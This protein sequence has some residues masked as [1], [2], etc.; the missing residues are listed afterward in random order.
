MLDI[1]T[2]EMIRFC[3]SGVSKKSKWDPEKEILINGYFKKK[4]GGFTG[5]DHLVLMDLTKT[6][7]FLLSFEGYLAI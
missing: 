5:L 7:L 4:P 1:F 6:L 3:H 2:A